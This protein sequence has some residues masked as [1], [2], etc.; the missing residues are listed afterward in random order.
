MHTDIP[1]MDGMPTLWQQDTAS[2][3][4]AKAS[5]AADSTSDKQV[6]KQTGLEPAAASAPKLKAPKETKLQEAAGRKAKARSQFL[7][8]LFSAPWDKAGGQDKASM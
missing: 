2:A 6:L 8:G 5:T 4:A 1:T 7:A 3:S